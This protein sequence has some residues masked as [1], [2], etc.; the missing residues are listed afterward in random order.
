MQSCPSFIAC[1]GGRTNLAFFSIL[2]KQRTEHKNAVFRVY[3]KFLIVPKKAPKTKNVSPL[4]YPL[5]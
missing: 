3:L 5:L 1:G 2:K 4:F